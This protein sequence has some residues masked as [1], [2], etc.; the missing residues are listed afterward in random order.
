MTIKEPL[1]IVADITAILTFIGAVWAWCH[2]HHGLVQKQKILEECLKVHGQPFK[3]KGEPGEFNFIY[4]IANTGLTES[5]II[6]ASFRSKLI[7]RRVPADS[8]GYAK[9]IRFRYND[10]PSSPAPV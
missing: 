7:E 5:E 10:S 1:E 3:E 8:E 4:I 9:E 2:Y 6:Q